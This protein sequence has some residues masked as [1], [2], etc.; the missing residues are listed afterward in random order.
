MEVRAIL[1]RPNENR[2][3]ELPFLS[4]SVVPLK[5][6][7]TPPEVAVMALPVIKIALLVA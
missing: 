3:K 2:A 4:V 1:L 5:Y 7:L 6:W